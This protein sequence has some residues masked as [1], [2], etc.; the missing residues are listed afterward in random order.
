MKQSTKSSLEARTKRRA[1]IQEPKQ[2]LI[3]RLRSEQIVRYVP[4]MLFAIVI[5]ILGLLVPRFLT[6]RNGINV[7]RQASALG[8][9]AIGITAVLIGGG[10]DLSIP[11]LMALGGILGTMYMGGGGNPILGG[12]IM[13]AVCTLGGMI[14]GYAVAY[15]KM[16]PFVVTLS[17]M[18]IAM[19]ASV[20][21]TREVS[22]AGLPPAFLDTVMANIWIIPVPVIFLFIVT[23]IVTFLMRNN[24]YGRWLYAVGSSPETARSLGVPRD[25]II[26]G[27]YVFS[28]FFAGLAAIIT[29]ARLVSASSR[30]GAE[31]VVLN[32]IA[33][34]VVG[35][36]SIYGGVG[37][38]LGAVIGAV[39]I[40]VIGNIMNLMHVTYYM[41]LVVKGCVIVAVIALDSLYRRR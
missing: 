5:I 14:N 18:Y 38:P 7:L 22:V 3:S 41:T 16:I 8:L 27:T 26:F 9:M 12:L 10:I 36:V 1:V 11:P 6:V 28:G 2:L 31:G 15:L 40:T 33:S 37:S 23:A 39:L 20:W 35:G 21:L 34:A 24:L 29:T 19:G 17:M 13:I 25:R 30:M 32:V 4:L